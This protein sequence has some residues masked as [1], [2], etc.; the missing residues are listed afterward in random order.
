[1]LPV[2]AALCGGGGALILPAC[3]T[4][5][6]QILYSDRWECSNNDEGQSLI[7]NI[8]RPAQVNQSGFYGEGLHCEFSH[9]HFEMSDIEEFGMM[10]EHALAA[11]RA[12]QGPCNG[13]KSPSAAMP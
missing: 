1:M 6:R 13:V 7:F 12:V 5:H 3:A 11:R 9:F 8:R 10:S 2:P 4:G